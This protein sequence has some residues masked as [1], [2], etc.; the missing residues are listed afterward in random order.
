MGRLAVKPYY[1]HIK[2]SLG[3]LASVA[4]IV[5]LNTV[6]C[7]ANQLNAGKCQPMMHME[8]SVES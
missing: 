5:A 2:H 4:S 8:K 6:G 1:E 3:S 7:V